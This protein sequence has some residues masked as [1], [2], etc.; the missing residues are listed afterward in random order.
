MS[1][2]RSPP[3]SSLLKTFDWSKSYMTGTQFPNTCAVC[4]Q[5]KQGTECRYTADG[6]GCVVA[7][8]CVFLFPIGLFALLAWPFLGQVVCYDCKP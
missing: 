3:W 4:K 5:G 8:L 1:L 7:F 2:G 6:M